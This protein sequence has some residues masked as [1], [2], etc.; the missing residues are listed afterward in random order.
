MVKTMA[1]NLIFKKPVAATVSFTDPRTTEHA[2]E[3]ENFIRREHNE[4]VRFLSTNGIDVL[5][6]MAKVRGESDEM[7]GIGS[8]SG[9][10]QIAEMIDSH[11]VD[12]LILGLWHWTEPELPLRLARLCGLPVALYTEDTPEWAGTVCL[13]AVGSSFWEIDKPHLTTHLRVRG[14]KSALLP[15]IKAH[16]A[17]NKLQHGSL[18]MWGGSYSLRMEHLRDDTSLM[19]SF[20][21]GDVISEDQYMLIKRADDIL[22]H[23]KDRI[24][25]FSTW[26]ASEG[27][28]VVHDDRMF[29]KN[30]YEKQVALHLAAVDR[31]SEL[32]GEDIIGVSI[33]CQPELSDEYGV[34]ACLLPGFLPF[35]LGPEGERSAVT[36]ACEG[37]TKGLYTCTALH[38][39]NPEIPPLFGDVKYYN[40]DVLIISNCGASSLEWADNDGH[41]GA[42]QG[43]TLKPQCQGA[44]GGALGYDGRPGQITIARL[45][46]I[47]GEYYMQAGVAE[48]IKMDN[49]VRNKIVW[50]DMWPH[51]ALTFGPGYDA[52][53]LDK[54]L[55]SNHLSA[56]Y[57]NRMASLEHLCRRLDVPMVRID[58]NESMLGFLDEIR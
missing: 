3:R 46:R 49:T 2:S 55:G 43:V 19:K 38:A 23:R 27:L 17:A 37:D 35:G 40:D 30:V 24:E 48:V 57:G 1:E 10:K 34:T 56:T 42:L 26:A 36:T 13:S 14:D 58:D 11:K 41:E 9:V 52:S 18:L 44:S 53:I 6:T 8:M 51:I 5:D 7:F 45:I 31:L 12:C 16:S 4:L 29:T 28:Q 50:G 32:K 54:A 20:F 47:A 22:A 39:L 21:V 15:W 25:S 33:K